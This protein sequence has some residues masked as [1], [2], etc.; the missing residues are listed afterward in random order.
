MIVECR[1]KL[2]EIVKKLNIKGEIYTSLA[3]LKTSGAI[4]FGAVFFET[5]KPV[6][7][8]ERKI[9]RT[10]AG[11]KVR[12]KK[13][14]DREIRFLVTLASK[15]SKVTETRYETFLSLLPEGIVDEE[16]NWIPITIE[17]T[18]WVD[19]DDSILRSEL[20]VQVLVLFHAGSWK[21]NKIVHMED[22]ETTGEIWKE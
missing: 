16:N 22:V 1:E 18:D 17:Q 11:E 12:R 13:L 19:K 21:D 14:F 8:T 4:D 6:R 20:S 2:I 3:R 15:E 9:F 10:K 5:E 7:S